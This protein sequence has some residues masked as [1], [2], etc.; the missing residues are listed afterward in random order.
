MH[1][2]RSECIDKKR[3]NVGGENKFLLKIGDKTMGSLTLARNKMGNISSK[4]CPFSRLSITFSIKL[5]RLYC[6]WWIQIKRN[7]ILFCFNEEQNDFF[8][9]LKACIHKA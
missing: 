7:Q 6:T 1:C 4:T 8:Q 9:A 5:S 3:R 2:D